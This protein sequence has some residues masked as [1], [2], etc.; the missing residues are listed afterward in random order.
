MHKVVEHGAVH[1]AGL[2]T[3]ATMEGR[4]AFAAQLAL[5]STACMESLQ[6]VARRFLDVVAGANAFD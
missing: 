6:G 5:K 3:G 2:G 1:L 4:S